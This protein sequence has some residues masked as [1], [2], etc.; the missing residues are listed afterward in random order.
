MTLFQFLIAL[1]ITAILLFT[2][3]AFWREIVIIGVVLYTL[4]QLLFW[5]LIS[6]ILWA[7]FINSSTDGWMLLWLYFFIL[8][9]GILITYIL[10]AVDIF[11]ITQNFIKSFFK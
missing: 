1:G 6:A 11:Y 3:R 5:S 8:Y 10:I 9:C 2:I 7:A 4:G